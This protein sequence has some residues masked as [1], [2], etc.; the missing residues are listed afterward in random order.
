MV[1]FQTLSKLEQYQDLYS[2]M[3]KDAHGF[4]P[5]FNP[6]MTVEDYEFEFDRLQSM[7]AADEEERRN[8]E[9]SNADA[10]E[11]RV[12]ELLTCGA[13]DR[14]MALRWIHEAEGSDGDDEYLCYLLGLRYGYFKG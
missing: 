1:E 10:F 7:I 3:Y 2:D 12:A 8:R 9:A 14:K 11:R 6:A 13:K 4:R 5:R